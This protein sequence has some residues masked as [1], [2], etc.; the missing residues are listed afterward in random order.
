MA[1][2]V[3]SRPLK[4]SDNELELYWLCS[5]SLTVAYR[6]DRQR[7]FEVFIHCPTVAETT[8]LFWPFD[9]LESTTT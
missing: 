8:G 6:I 7:V 3:L 4:D 9:H 5:P 2:M 1:L